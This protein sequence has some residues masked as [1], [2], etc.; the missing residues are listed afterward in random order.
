[1]SEHL[2]LCAG[3]TFR[4][5]GKRHTVRDSDLTKLRAILTVLRR[6]AGA[7]T[8]ITYQQL[9]DQARLTDTP[10]GLGRP[11]HLVFLE[12]TLADEPPLDALVVNTATSEV[13]ESH[14]GDAVEQRERVFAHH[15]G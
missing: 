5:Q 8:T 12:C 4:F 1:M 3:V 2:H 11:L 14:R 6:C 13:G 9:I 10:I 15:A 7:R